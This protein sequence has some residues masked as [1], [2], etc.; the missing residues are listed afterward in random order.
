M[1]IAAWIMPKRRTVPHKWRL[2]RPRVGRWILA[3]RGVY[4]ITDAG[5]MAEAGPARMEEAVATGV[6]VSRLAIEEVAAGEV[7]TAEASSGSAGQE[8]PPEVAGEAVKEASPSVRTSKPPEA[9]A[10]ASS[11][12][13]PARGVK[14]DMPMPGRRLAWPSIPLSSEQ[15]PAL[16]RL[17]R[18][19]TLPS[20]WRPTAAKL[21]LLPGWHPKALRVENPRGF[22]RVWC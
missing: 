5:V 6:I 1:P 11:S 4:A 3:A 12:P 22:D 13:G 19:L 9:V 10:Q 16:R 15:P 21:P 8:D 14:A 18:E 17:L 2:V 20:Q 7:S